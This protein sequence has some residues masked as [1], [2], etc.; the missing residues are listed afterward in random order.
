MGKDGFASTVI[1]WLE[2][3][4]THEELIKKARE[5]I[6][7]LDGRNTFGAPSGSYDQVRVVETTLIYFGSQARSDY[8]EV[9]LNS[10]TGDPI[11]VVYPPQNGAGTT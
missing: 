1:I 6:R 10:Q 11:S 4:V 5:H 2:V 3:A 7:T 8:I 9:V